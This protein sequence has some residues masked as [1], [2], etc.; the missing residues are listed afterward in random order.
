[1]C[2]Y[3]YYYCSYTRE[4]S[5]YFDKKCSVCLSYYLL[6]TF[7]VDDGDRHDVGTRELVVFRNETMV[8]GEWHDCDCKNPHETCGDEKIVDDDVLRKVPRI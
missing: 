8:P 5:C 3:Y 4:S 1:M 6:D 7:R 2:C